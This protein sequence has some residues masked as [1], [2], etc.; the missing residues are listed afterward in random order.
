MSD[1]RELVPAQIVPM[2]CGQLKAHL[3]TALVAEVPEGNPTRAVL[4]KVG[5]F[6]ENPKKINVSVSITPG[7][8]EDPDYIDGRIDN[9][10]FDNLKVANLPV[11]EIGG[12][13]FWW[14]RG[15]IRVQC[16]FVTQRYEEDVAMQYAYDFLGRLQSAVGD[17]PIGLLVDDYGERAK[18]P[19]Y[20]E[21][22]SFFPSGGNNKFIWRGKLLWRVLTWRPT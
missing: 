20:V 12:G 16:F 11:G 2:I 19:V 21:S 9:P 8:Y 7:D 18:P 17:A 5:L 13:E 22:H 10:A 15:S 4:V 1:Y 14:R 3:D 6:Q